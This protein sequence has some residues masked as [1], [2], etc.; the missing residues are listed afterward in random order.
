MSDNK[1]YYYLKLKDNFFDTDAMII[2][3]NMQDGYLY[4]NI[5]LKLYLRGLKNEGKLMFNDFI[6]YNSSVLAQVT[7]HQVGTVEKA[8]KTFKELGLVDIL[9]NGAIYMLDIQ[10]YIGSS[11]SEADR[12]RSYRK[13]I[14]A[15]KDGKL[16]E[17][18]ICPDKSTDKNPPEIEIELK[19]ELELEKKIENPLVRERVPYDDIKD[20]FISTCTRLPKIKQLTE[21]RKNRLKKIYFEEAEENI[22]F[23]KELFETVAKSDFLNGKSERRWRADFDWILKPANLIRILE[24]KYESIKPEQKSQYA[25]LT[26]AGGG[27][28]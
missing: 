12:K 24:G 4:S 1:K 2:L 16:I 11:S 13:R 21:P 7:R 5:L 17:G 15:E 10:N 28:W 6:P 19:K 14:D 9:D 26:G 3:E 23:F 27:E 20:L 8:L 18:D 22:I 25:D